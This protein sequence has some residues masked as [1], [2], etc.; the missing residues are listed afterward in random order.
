MTS[1][2][3]FGI[4]L[5]F[6]GAALLSTVALY[7]RQSLLVAYIVIGCIMGPAGLELIPNVGVIKNAGAI[8]ILFLLFLL[9]LELQPQKFFHVL[10]KTAPVTIISSIVFFLIGYGIGFLF[11]F[12][13]MESLII[14]VS[15]MFSSTIIGLKLL[16]TTILHHRHT[17]EIMISILLM[18]DL[19]AIIVLVMLSGVGSHGVSV[20]DF[21]ELGISF[22]LLLGT[23][24]IVERFVLMPCIKR[25]SQTHEYIFLVAIGWCLGMSELAIWMGLS[26]EIGA[27]VA[28]VTLAASPIAHYLVESLKPLRDFFLVM[29]FFSI[30]AG[31]EFGYLG[32]I[33]W[34]ALL[35]SVLLLLIKPTL[36]SALLRKTH[37]SKAVSFEIGVRLGQG[38]EFSLLLGGLAVQ[39][40][41]IHV[42][43]A[44]LIQTIMI[45]TFVA[46]S[47]WVVLKYP[48]PMS[49]DSELHKD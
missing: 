27:F 41:L 30:G 31:F 4:F 47:Y 42:K 34:P 2:I 24:F 1:S 45:L 16:P 36:F 28:G 35:L 40:A 12:T 6:T 23:A 21:L 18:Q 8:G 20:M 25:F 9:G 19:I 13:Q 44:Y 39:A 22:P 26:E 32:E 48:T 46:S 37:E 33:I 15:M 3:V 38:S 29:F 14:G 43:V 7:T 5:M 17:G 10:R 49:M 11:K